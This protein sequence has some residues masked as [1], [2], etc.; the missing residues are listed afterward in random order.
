MLAPPS[1]S[2]SACRSSTPIETLM[3]FMILLILLSGGSD[4]ETDN[5]IGTKFVLLNNGNDERMTS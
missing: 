3:F 5:S 1:S 2:W 4:G